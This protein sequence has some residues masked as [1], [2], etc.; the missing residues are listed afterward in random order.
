MK[1]DLREKREAVV[2]EHVAAE[3]RGDLDGV[4]ASFSHPRYQVIPMGADIDGETPVRDLIG[5][6]IRGFP[7]FHFEPL[8]IHHADNAVIVEGRMTGTHRAEWAGMQPQGGRF[9]VRLA[10]IFDFDG[11]KLVNET[12]YFDFATL[13]R[14]LG[15][16]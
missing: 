9:D 15:Q 7:D 4:I 11:E 6:L 12:V 3:N 2:R 8:S 14:Q 13:Q 10:C 16:P 1:N 5:G